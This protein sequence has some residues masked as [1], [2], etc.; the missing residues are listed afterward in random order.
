MNIRLVIFLVPLVIISSTAFS[1]EPGSEREKRNYRFERIWLEEGLSQSSV[2][3][4]YQDSRGFLWIGTED[5]LNRYDGYSFKV[6]RSEPGNSN[7]LGSNFIRAIHESP[8]GILWIGTNGGGLNRYDTFTQ[9]FTRYQAADDSSGINNNYVWDIHEDEDGIFWIATDGGGLNRFDPVTGGF[10]HY[11]HSEENKHSLSDDAVISVSGDQN[12]NIWLGTRSGGLNRFDPETGSFR[13]YRHDR[14]DPYSIGYGAI[15]DIHPNR[16]G[17]LWIATDGGGLNLFNPGSERF[18][19]FMKIPGDPSGISSN[20]IYSVYTDRSGIIWLGTCEGGLVRLNPESGVFS[21]YR[22]NPYNLNSLS[23]NSVYCVLEDRSGI[24]WVGTEI[25]GLNKLDKNKIDFNNYQHVPN[26]P[27]SLNHPSVWAVYEDLRGILWVGTSGGGLNR[28]DRKRDEIRYYTFDSRDV[29]SISYNFVRVIYEAPSQP[30][31]LWLGTDAGG[32]NRLDTETDSITHFLNDP[33]DAGSIS[34]NRIYS[35]LED[36]RE[37]FWVGTRTG[38]L[39]LF[40]RENGTFSSYRKDPEDPYSICDDFIYRIF[41]DSRGDIWVGT[42]S[43]GLCRFDGESGVFENFRNMVED[44]TSLS[45][46]CV[47]TMFED[48]DGYLWVGTGG[49]GLNRFSR[50][51]GTFKRYGE[52]DGLPNNVVYAILG[53]DN[54]NLWLS[55]NLG[56]T[57]FNPKTGLFR[58]YTV[59]DGLQ[60]NEFNGGS[61]YRSE[62]GEMFFGGVNGLTAL[63]PGRI[64]ENRYRPPVVITDLMVFNKSLRIGR[65]RSSRNILEKSIFE[66]DEI[67][68]SHDQNFITIEFAALDFTVP[69]KNRYMH[70]LKGFDNNWVYTTGERRFSTYKNLPPGKY[71]F[72]VKG[73]NSDGV[74]SDESASLSIIIEPSLW[75]TWWFRT[76]ILSASIFSVVLLY[77]RRVRNVRVRAELRAAHEAQMAIMPHEDP[78]NGFFEI[79]GICLPAFEVG[80]DF[81]DYIWLDESREKLGI[82]IGDV[83]GKAM[84]AAMIAVMSNGMVLSGASECAS[85]SRFMTKLNRSMC[86]KTDERMFT[87]MFLASFNIR[88]GEF[89]FS[90]AGISPP[91]L[92]NG[93]GLRSITVDGP[94]LPL[95]A[96]NNTTY[97]EKSIKLQEGDVLLMYTDGITEARN[98]EGAF[99]DLDKLKRLLTGMNTNRMTS[100]DILSSIVENVTAFS[101]SKPRDDD[102]TLIVIKVNGGKP[103]T[104]EEPP[105]ARRHNKLKSA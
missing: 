82:V 32:L 105:L 67:R 24:L 18:I 58:N 34:G 48:Q 70:I 92:K 46:N 47:L 63:F 53:D 17:S 69:G 25:R 76:L 11:R 98:R 97:R 7:S 99:Y 6:L 5:G 42:F 28:L 21:S 12:G 62:S 29:N 2:R 50:D 78:S 13:V 44:S 94:C 19:R 102:M 61:Y 16:D 100:Y 39:N 36:S 103:L 86:I 45:N 80:G 93:K 91:L 79:S 14:A 9:T 15:R 87:A 68:L 71:L 26:E 37:R 101:G 83:S 20:M 10:R 88:D 90:N 30:G 60:S 73:S 33:E 96:L 81:Y 22:H 23:Y 95:G 38:G 41:E 66:T 35:I 31:I 59:R 77:R 65:G 64:R 3:V 40:D 43:G 4:L 57:R 85:P 52:K 51:T 89:T 72:T 84:K 1:S 104:S 55:T 56:L 8:Y 49:G 75:G 27:V 54:G 74:W